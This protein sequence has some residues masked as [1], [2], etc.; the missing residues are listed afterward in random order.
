MND[1]K[2][3]AKAFQ[4]TPLT[5]GEAVKS[6][7]NIL[8][9]LT[10]SSGLGI[11]P[12]GP[13]PSQLSL[14]GT[15]GTAGIA[16]AKSGDKEKEATDKD[17]AGTAAHGQQQQ[18][19]QQQTRDHD[20]HKLSAVSLARTQRSLFKA[21][22]TLKLSI[23]ARESWTD[24]ISERLIRV[25][26]D[27]TMKAQATKIG[28]RALSACKHLAL[29]D[30]PFAP[31]ALRAVHRLQALAE[32][33]GAMTF[34][35]EAT[36]GTSKCELT[37]SGGKF[38]VVFSFP[39]LSPQ[40]TLQVNVS[41]EF[42][43]ADDSN[44]AEPDIANSFAQ[45]LR[46]ERFDLIDRAFQTL[47]QV[48]QLDKMVPSA[49]LCDALH[50]FEDTILDTHALERDASAA[51]NI[52]MLDTYGHG[53]IRRTALGV[54]IMYMPNH[55]VLLGIEPSSINRQICTS[56]LQILARPSQ[57]QQNQNQ[58]QPQPQPQLSS[59]PGSHLPS[60]EFVDGESVSAHVQYVLT[61]HPAVYVS[62]DVARL[63][64]RVAGG[65]DAVKAALRAGSMRTA[66][67]RDI[68]GSREAARITDPGDKRGLWPNLQTLLAPSV[69]G[70]QHSPQQ[71]GGGGG[72]TSSASNGN[73]S[74]GQQL[75]TS[76]TKTA[77]GST[78][79]INTHADGSAKARPATLGNNNAQPGQPPASSS[80]SSTAT[81]TK[82]KQS[83]QQDHQH[84][85]NE[86][87]HWS[88][89][90]TEV[91]CAT[92]LPNGQYIEF[93]HSGGDVVAA[94][95]LKRVPIRHPR[96]VHAVLA[97]LR[98]QI[99]F[100]QLFQSC[101]TNNPV[102]KTQRQPVLRQA[103]EVAFG[104]TPSFLRLSMFDP[105]LDDIV[106]MVVHIDLGGDARVV[107]RCSSGRRHVCSNVKATAILRLS[108]SVPLTI[109]TILQ[110]SASSST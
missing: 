38:M 34:L 13:T 44:R 28:K 72:N 16:G 99:V 8:R 7:Q 56:R 32:Q 26:A 42:L 11:I 6:I 37:V 67:V 55:S 33:G 23:A 94:I 31:R 65:E 27:T 54:R 58:P 69:F 91:C 62:L 88:Q 21:L 60:I 9:D 97:V 40:S 68:S 108:R 100:N 105:V 80:S 18:Q 98:Q 19:Q 48:E 15:N 85:V 75:N 51:L 49:S 12:D 2:P 63:L 52:P 107:L 74:A 50:A 81:A 20:V 30:D 90:S 76:P 43:N 64:E 41:F 39:D 71:G 29:T 22:E 45:L 87:T 106:S 36:P 17:A 104:D 66:P 3:S 61:L 86:R 35:D 101:F 79:S 84:L 103:V 70:H 77:I 4:Q 47:M 82:R 73:P 89:T 109:H 92:A 78:G 46:N 110:V 5:A 14:P 53:L 96:D 24:G 25:K 10:G 95:A 102:A 93:T 1:S 83:Q 57:Q 59:S